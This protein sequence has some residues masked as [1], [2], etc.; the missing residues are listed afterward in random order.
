MFEEHSTLYEVEDNCKLWQYMSF[1][2][3][4]NLLLGK[5]YFRRIDSFEDVFEGTWPQLNKKYI[6]YVKENE[7]ETIGQFDNIARKLLYVSCFHQA[8]EETAF[9]W[10]QYADKDG[11]AILTS[12]KRIKKSFHLT[13][14][15]V[16]LSRVKYINYNCEPIYDMGNMFSLVIHKRKS[17]QYEKEVRCIS[18]LND[19]YTDSGINEKYIIDKGK[20]NKLDFERLPVGI[21][22]DID[23]LHLIEKVYI[24]PYADNYI[25]E[26]VK[27]WMEMKH[28]DVETVKSELYSIK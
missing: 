18:L 19:L 10:K 28:L 27:A 4:V 7:N 24:S 25:W 11:V 5:M 22:V 12:S 3:F 16:Y 15:P 26:N 21:K 2:K 6:K 1:S 9:M 14:S 20:G 13:K 17:F 8:D 23:L